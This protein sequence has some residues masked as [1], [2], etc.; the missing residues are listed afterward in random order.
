MDMT[1]DRN[2][3]LAAMAGAA[4]LASVGGVIAGRTIFSPDTAP[5]PVAAPEE[6]EGEE[7]HGPEGF[8]AMDAS[9]LAV[10]GIKTERTAAGSLGAEV[11]A[12]ATVSAA[13]QLL[14]DSTRR[15]AH[16]INATTSRRIPARFFGTSDVT[17]ALPRGGLRSDGVL[18]STITK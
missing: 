13:R 10:A 1:N 12:Q 7:E 15:L 8:V 17:M 11:I 9:R 5:A 6:G 18:S 3:L 14:R 16:A 4:L 2:K